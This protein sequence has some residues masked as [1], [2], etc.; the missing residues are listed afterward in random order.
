MHYP[1]W[2]TQKL[3]SMSP[4]LKRVRSLEAAGEK[5]SAWLTCLLNFDLATQLDEQIWR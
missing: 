2:L 3:N 1:V 4:D 5:E